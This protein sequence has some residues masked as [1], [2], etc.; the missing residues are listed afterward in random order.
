MKTTTRLPRQE[1]TLLDLVQSVMS[2]TNS[3][4]E[5]VATIVYLINSGRVRLCGTFAGA[6]ITLPPAVKPFP[7]VTP[8]RI[9][10]VARLTLG[11]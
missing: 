3:D 7:H 1:S 9:A 8:S 4:E 5:T 2:V 10:H 11:A 6:K